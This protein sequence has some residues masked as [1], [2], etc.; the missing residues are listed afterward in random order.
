VRKSITNPHPFC[1]L[2]PN[3]AA[4]LVQYKHNTIHLCGLRVVLI[5]V[6]MRV[7]RSDGSPLELRVRNK[8]CQPHS[9]YKD[10][11]K[12]VV[13]FLNGWARPPIQKSRSCHSPK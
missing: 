11:I 12:Q 8:N 13:P 4:P 2:L 10:S 9:C 7:Q 6:I 1:S 5:F 3:M